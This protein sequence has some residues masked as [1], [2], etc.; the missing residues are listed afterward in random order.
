MAHDT[1]RSCI[2]ACNACAEAC[3]HCAAACLK[4]PDVQMMARC[5]ALDIAGECRRMAA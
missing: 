4:E 1:Y 5:V 2:D 3:D